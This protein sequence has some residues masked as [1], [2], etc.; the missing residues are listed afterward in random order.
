VVR[1]FKALNSHFILLYKMIHIITHILIILAFIIIE[2]KDKKEQER[3][4]EI[5]LSEN[6]KSKMNYE[7]CCLDLDRSVNETSQEMI[8][9]DWYEIG[10]DQSIQSCED[11]CDGRTNKDEWA[12]PA[13]N[14]CGNHRWKRGHAKGSCGIQGRSKWKKHDLGTDQSMIGIKIQKKMTKKVVRSASSFR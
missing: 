1:I 5:A 14:I 10:A 13:K 4:K 8:S 7:S 11:S 12:R 3:K 2:C 9:T 6:K